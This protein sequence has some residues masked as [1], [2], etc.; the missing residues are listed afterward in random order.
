VKLVTRLLES[1]WG[2]YAWII[3]LILALL[4]L[5]FVTIVPFAGARSWLSTLCCR[6]AF[7]LSGIPVTLEGSDDLPCGHV[8][9]V[10]NHASYVDGPLLKG[11]LPARFSRAEVTSQVT[12]RAVARSPDRIRRADQ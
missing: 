12:G 1:L 5:L 11:F 3:F 8:V 2:I 7:L 4:A 9:V 10:A 6:A